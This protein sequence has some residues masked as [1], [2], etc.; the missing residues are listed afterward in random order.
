[1]YTYVSTYHTYKLFNTI[2]GIMECIFHQEIEQNS[3]LVLLQ[4]HL[5]III[6][7][8]FRLI[9]VIIFH[10]CQFCLCNLQL[11]FHHFA[12]KSILESIATLIDN[13]LDLSKNLACITIHATDWT[14][15][16]VRKPSGNQT[17]G[18]CS[19][20]WYISTA[21][22]PALPADSQSEMLFTSHYDLSKL[23][24]DGK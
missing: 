14:S 5:L 2:F 22:L 21:V 17:R 18:R 24:I 15:G 6:V 9:L 10:I 4:Q 8:S 23:V 20:I 19:E 12:L 16:A 7:S 1:M 13:P 3:R 11:Q